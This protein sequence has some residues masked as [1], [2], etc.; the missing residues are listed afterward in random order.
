MF[1]SSVVVFAFERIFETERKSIKLS[2]SG[3]GKDLGRVGRRKINKC[4]DMALIIK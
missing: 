3:G 4:E 1:L 2:G